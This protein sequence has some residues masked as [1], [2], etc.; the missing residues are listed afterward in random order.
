MERW[1]PK[2]IDGDRVA[3]LARELRV[4][5]A[6]ARCLVARGQE[7]AA[8]AAR[9]LDP[10]LGDLRP[11][12]GMAGF[13]RAVDRL[14]AAVR[15]GQR[16]GIFGDYD[17]D[18]VT[19]TALLTSFLRQVGADVC[20]R[21]ARRDAGYGFGEGDAEWFASRGCALVVTVDCG[22]SDRPAILACRAR[23]IDVI[24]VDHHQVPDGTEHPA[25]SLLNPHRPDSSYPFRGLASVGLGFFLA[26]AL[27]TALRA[28]GWFAARA[29]PDPRRLLDLV[30]VGTVA[31]LAP[32]TDENRVLV[33][34]G[35]RELSERRRP[36]LAA[37]LARA[38]VEGDRPIDE[39]DI[40][41]KL[42]PRL[43]APGRLGDA[44]PALELLLA[45]DEREAA[46]R[47]D[48][49]EQANEQRRAITGTMIE[50][51]LAD[52]AD[53]DDAAIVVARAG[54]HPGV[55][56][57][58]AAKLV[59]RFGR[60]AAVIAI[61]AASGEGRGSVRSVGGFDLVAALASCR[62]HLIRFGGHAA[63]AG[64]TVAQDQIEPLRHRFAAEA[65]RAGVA[66]PA[67]LEVDAVVPLGDVDP[68]L[69][70][71]LARLA[72]FGMGNDEPLV[73][74]PETRVRQTRRVGE[75]GSHLRLTLECSRYATSHQAI[76]F[77]MGERDPGVGA[78]LDI[79]Y[80]PAL[81]QWRGQ[82]R[83]ELKVSDFWVS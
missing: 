58:V 36:G 31:D 21:V 46:D 56:G 66:P 47:A 77:R 61:D 34:H 79:A 72:P 44:R 27:R 10:R 4:R 55:A 50:E 17:V 40:G 20:P 30:A 1:R 48:V 82:T 68:S 8:R 73:A 60:P 11:P 6:T 5:P 70:A 35:L 26:A 59:D 45:A 12:V 78:T 13:P 22:T 3:R 80:C 57:I 38:G 28:A 7:D 18:G 37:L 24:V 41:W 67:P 43:N 69:A 29:E 49:L 14:V 64:L 9:F 42:G 71:E 25:L 19:T 39:R 2:D 65:A 74:A 76:A 15:A 63:A 83:L 33:A 62:E 52:A 23:D 16:I 32:L 53:L 81:S 54:W 75:D 51:A